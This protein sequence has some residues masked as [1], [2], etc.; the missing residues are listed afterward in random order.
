MKV[1]IFDVAITGHHL[2]YLHHF[3]LGAL[4]HPEVEFYFFVSPEFEKK[5]EMFEWFCASNIKILYSTKEQADK[6][7]KAKMW[8]LGA[9]ETLLLRKIVNKVNPDYVLLTSLTTIIPLACFLLPRRVKVQG[10]I[11]TIYSYQK[12]KL[13][14]L[15]LNLERMRWYVSSKSKIIN[16]VFLLNDPVNCKEWN[17]HYN[18]NKFDYL[19]D[20]VPDISGQ[21][22]KDVRSQFNIPKESKVFLHFGG[23][24]ERK[25]TLNILKAILLS[26]EDELKDKVFIFAGRIYNEIKTPFYELLKTANERTK[27]I[28]FDDFVS[29][30][31]IYNLCFSTDFIL[32]P[33]QMS[34][35]SS[36]VIG[37]ASLFKKTVIGPQDGLIG[38][39]IRLYNLGYTIDASDLN[40][41]SKSFGF[42]PKPISSAY[43]DVSTRE[44]FLIRFFDFLK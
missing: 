1:L 35:L 37:Y 42:S 15:R 40:S 2:E 12:E 17:K 5:K 34:N 22:F 33:Y 44:N 8:Q 19:P 13:S 16:K 4:D 11:Y 31:F 38:N 18:T 23:M 43:A 14:A 36:G 27:I 24:A 39:L 25:G 7:A 9:F 21:E 6:C 3:Y 41:I 30:E 28:V 20:P 26:P 32:I 10:I 29:Y